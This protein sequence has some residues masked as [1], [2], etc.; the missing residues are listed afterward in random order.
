MPPGERRLDRLLRRHVTGAGLEIIWNVHL[1]RVGRFK[2]H[3]EVSSSGVI[4]DLSL[5]GA[6]VEVPGDQDHE[7]GECVKI[8][9]RGAD[10]RV[11]IRHRRAGPE[12]RILYGVKF[13]PDVEFINEVKDAVGAMRGHAHEL[14]AA[15]KRQN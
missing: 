9:F 14:N 13:F 2:K 3:E 1:V 4:R 8:V 11:E 15:W 5:E 7:I 12:G 6:L 10:G